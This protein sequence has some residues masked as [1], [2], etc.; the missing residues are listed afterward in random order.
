MTKAPSER[1]LNAKLKTRLQEERVESSDSTEENPKP[2]NRRDGHRSKTIEGEFGQ[3]RIRVPRNQNSQFERILVAKG[4]TRFNG[5]DDK[6][7]FLYARGMITRNIQDQLREFHGIEVSP[8]LIS[9]VLEAV[10]AERKEWQGRTLD[11]VPDN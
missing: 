1:C 10:E 4:Q 11:T 5:F 3:S 9:K 7:L 6:I 8:E 2:K